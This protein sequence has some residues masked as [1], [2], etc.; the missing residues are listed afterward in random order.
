MWPGAWPA[1]TWQ[2][3]TY[4][5][6]GDQRTGDEGSLGLSDTA[7]CFVWA[8]VQTAHIR[9]AVLRATDCAGLGQRRTCQQA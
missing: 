9:G 8:A 7:W 2:D 1:G 5:L 6:E 3:G 4:G